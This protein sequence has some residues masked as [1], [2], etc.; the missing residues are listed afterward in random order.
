MKD[1][2]IPRIE[3]NSYTEKNREKIDESLVSLRLIREIDEFLEY[4]NK[5]NKE[6][7]IDLGFTESYISQLLSGVKKIN[8]AFI[9]KFE[10]KYNVYFDFKLHLKEEKEYLKYTNEQMTF[11]INIEINN[12]D[13]RNTFFTLHTKTFN[14]DSLEVEE[15]EIL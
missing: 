6:F 15:A 1:K 2:L 10:K 8:M 5:S 9:N 12:Q 11:N 3:F 7:A 13:I 4:K 14:S